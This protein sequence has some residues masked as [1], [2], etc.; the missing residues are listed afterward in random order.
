MRLSKAYISMLPVFAAASA[1]SNS[2]PVEDVSSNQDTSQS[3][4][5]QSSTGPLSSE[6]TLLLTSAVEEHSLE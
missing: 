3:I 4:N 2:E 6:E 5:V 1:N